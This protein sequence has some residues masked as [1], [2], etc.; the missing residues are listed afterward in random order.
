[1]A[2]YG[3]LF[4]GDPPSHN[5]CI[6]EA[7]QSET[8]QVLEFW[9]KESFDWQR[10]NK[11]E[12]LLPDAEGYDGGSISVMSRVADAGL[13][14]EFERSHRQK[15][16]AALRKIL[17][18]AGVENFTHIARLLLAIDRRKQL[19]HL[20]AEQTAFSYSSVAAKSA[21][22]PRRRKMEWIWPL[23]SRR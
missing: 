7:M 2:L 6:G 12:R 23:I 15:D 10:L 21:E 8:L 16:E 22:L 5:G 14:D 18:D 3:D 11:F 19:L 17:S 20:A 13:S 9:V 4:V 1:M